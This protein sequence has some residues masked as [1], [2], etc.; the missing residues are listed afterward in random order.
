MSSTVAHDRTQ[1]SDWF[2]VSVSAVLL[3]LVVVGFSQ[4][5]YLR[6]ITGTADLPSAMREL[7]GRLHLHGTVLS[8]WFVLALVQPTLIASRR[9]RIHRLL[10]WVGVALAL[11]VL[12]AT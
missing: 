10:G 5:Y 1:S 3:L 12:A 7:P 2:Y 6:P 11:A 9:T 4:T 8:M